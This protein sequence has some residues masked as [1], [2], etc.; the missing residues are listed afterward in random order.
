MSLAKFFSKSIE[1]SPRLNRVCFLK[2]KQ[3]ELQTIHLKKGPN[4]IGRT[5]ETGIRDVRCSKRQLLLDVDLEK[6]Q[7]TLEV[8]GVNPCSLNGFMANQGTKVVALHGDVLEIVYGRHPFEIVFK[9]PP[10]D[11]KSEPKDDDDEEDKE[12][13]NTS[14]DNSKEAWQVL[15]NGKLVVFTSKAVKS[16]AKIA[17]YDMDG[18]IITTKSGNVFP[19]NTED[20]QIIYPEVPSKLKKLIE[21]GYKICFFTNQGGIAKGK[22]KLE[23]FKQKIKGICAKLNIPIQVFIAVGDGF[24]RKPVPGMWNQLCEKDNDGI[25]IDMKE[26]FYVGDAAGRDAEGKKKKDHSCCDRLFALNLGLTFFTPEEHFLGKKPTSYDLPEFNPGKLPMNLPHIEPSHTKIPS[27]APCELIVLVGLPGSG[28]SEFSRS[29]LEP[30]GYTVLNA[31]IL[32][33][34][35]ACVSRCQK[36]LQAQQKCVIDNTN[37]DVETR[38]KYVEIAKRFNVP[39]RCFQMNTTPSQI[40]HNIAFRQ[41]TDSKHSKINQMILNTMKKK[42]KEPS[43]AE[44]FTEIAKVNLKYEFKSSDEEKLYKLYLV[45]K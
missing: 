38:K 21:D 10:S 17:G 45:E 1:Q 6:C 34:S 37:V 44:G 24:Y 43:L 42:C 15:E 27:D 2:P 22:I 13:S 12:D 28:K 26:S 36:A 41:L 11:S 23:D 7:V 3:A 8:L 25:Q 35:A 14:V 40:Q 9:P 4:E 29:T 33:S 39:C 30:L 32:G 20:W 5:K 16:S 19:K 31:D 18:T